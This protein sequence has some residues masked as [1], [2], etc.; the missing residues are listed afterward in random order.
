[1]PAGVKVFGGSVE[2][3]KT[4]RWV[5]SNIGVA[6]VQPSDVSE[7]E[8]GKNTFVFALSIRNIFIGFGWHGL[9]QDEFQ[10]VYSGCATH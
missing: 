6:V 3:E 1:V 2:P 5:Q 8:N 4:I 7:F 10:I 9:S